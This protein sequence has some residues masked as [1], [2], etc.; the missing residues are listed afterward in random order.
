MATKKTKKMGRPASKYVAVT[1]Y[2]S[3]P[4]DA[5]LKDMM[6][7]GKAIAENIESEYDTSK[8]TVKKSDGPYPKRTKKAD[9]KKAAVKKDQSKKKRAKA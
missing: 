3:F 4:P 7:L 2:L 1:V 9:V 5:K 6:S 8:I